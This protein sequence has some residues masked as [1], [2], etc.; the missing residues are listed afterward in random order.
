MSF[1]DDG[2]SFNGDLAEVVGYLIV[3]QREFN[4]VCT[5]KLRSTSYRL[6]QY[7]KQQLYVLLMRSPNGVKI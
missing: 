2:R 5:K 1:N 6:N 3:A 4:F 7:K